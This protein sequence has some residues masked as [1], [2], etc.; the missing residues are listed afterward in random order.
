MVDV[1]GYRLNVRQRGEAKPGVPIV[2]F[3]NGLGTPLRSWLRVQQE[4]STNTRTI[5]YDRSGIGSSELGKDAPTPANIARQ[6]HT[7]L[8]K[9]GA[10]PPYILVGHS[11][12]GPLSHAF[13]TTYPKEVA[14]LVYVDPTDF[15]QTKADVQELW[16][17]AGAPDGEAALD[18]IGEQSLASAPPG[19]Q[20]ETREVMKANQAGFA[21]LFSQMGDAPDV[22]IVILLA[23][24]NPAFPPG[25]SFPGNFDKFA[26]ALIAQRVDH[27]GQMARRAKNGVMMVVGTSG[28]FIQSREPDTVV[29]AIR[30]VLTAASATAPA[31]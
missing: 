30:R 6:L 1:G 20:L 19:V 12:G 3:E 29:W 9:V 15:T 21:A 8:A 31:K 27:F 18:K 11:Y 5:S 4:I 16:D 22:P 23:G 28:H 14:G 13:A 2:V 25:Q 10:P 7:L 17:K 26:H 24:Q